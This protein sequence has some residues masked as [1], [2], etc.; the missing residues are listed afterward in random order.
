M[1]L[2]VGLQ[3]QF[4]MGAFVAKQSGGVGV[5][6]EMGRQARS[7][8]SNS[9]TNSHVSLVVMGVIPTIEASTVKLGVKSLGDGM[10]D[11]SRISAVSAHTQSNQNS[12]TSDANSSR[13]AAQ[14][15]NMKTADA[16]AMIGALA[17][18]DSGT[19]QM[20]DINTMMTA[21]TDFVN[22]AIDGNVGVPINYYIKPITEKMLSKLWVAKYLPGQYI[23][24][25]SADDSGLTDPEPAP[26]AAAAAGPTSA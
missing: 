12:V 26:A 11:M 4:D 17:T 20:L 9:V 21:F 5:D 8:L 7:L 16:T 23:T 15:Q 1:Q 25:E 14:L 10:L 24:M 3:V 6:A 2:A 22:K 13:V 19:N 18:V